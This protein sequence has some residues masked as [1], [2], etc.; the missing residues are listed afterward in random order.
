MVMIEVPGYEHPDVRWRAI[1]LAAI[2]ASGLFFLMVMV[3]V[4]RSQ[5]VADAATPPIVPVPT[6]TVT[7]PSRMGK[8]ACPGDYSSEPVWPICTQTWED[9]QTE[10]L[11]FPDGSTYRLAVQ[12]P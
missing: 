4:G 8:I 1:G 2:S 3:L 5:P 9:D 10:T 7:A 6:V 12:S 11:T